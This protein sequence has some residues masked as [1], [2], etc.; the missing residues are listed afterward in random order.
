VKKIVSSGNVYVK[1]SSIPDSGRGVF[2]TRS[3]KKGEIIEVCPF[4]DIPDH[5]LENLSQSMLITY[6]FFYGEK[7]EKLLIALG[8]GSLYNHSYSPNAKYS[9][10][11]A[12]QTIRFIAKKTIC[13]DSEITFDYKHGNPQDKN[14]LWFEA[15]QEEVF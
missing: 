3:I 10:N 4:I 1:Q 12:D 8:F 11:E 2:A 5:D 13:K 14:P 7:K 6:T 15:N 9:I